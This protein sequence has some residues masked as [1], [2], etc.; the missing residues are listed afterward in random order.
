M[1]SFM[2]VI[3]FEIKKAINLQTQFSRWYL[4][5]IFNL[6]KNYISINKRTELL[7]GTVPVNNSLLT[8]IYYGSF[9]ELVLEIEG[10]IFPP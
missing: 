4:S 2:L 6:G 9:F 5:M 3:K 1:S 10:I 8:H 7:T